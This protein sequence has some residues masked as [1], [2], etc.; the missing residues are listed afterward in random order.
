MVYIVLYRIMCFK[1]GFE[2]EYVPMWLVNGFKADL[3]TPALIPASVPFTVV[4]SSERSG[5]SV[6]H[7]YKWGFPKI[8]GT[9]LGVPIIGTIVLHW[10]PPFRETTK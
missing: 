4:S 3:K 6:N 2:E 10:G 8:R 7:V 1:E 9:F 5:V